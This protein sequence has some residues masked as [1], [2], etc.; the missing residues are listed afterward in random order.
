VADNPPGKEPFASTFVLLWRVCGAYPW[1]VPTMVL[2]GLMA[3]LAE[4]LGIGLLIPA[5]DE[6]LPGS[7]LGQAPG[8]L[9]SQLRQWSEWLPADSRLMVLGLA[10]LALVGLKTLTLIANTAL[11]S[12]VGTRIAHDMRNRLTEAVLGMQYLR[13][14]D[15]PAG[16]LINLLET[17]AY[18]TGE[19]VAELSRLLV[20]LCTVV[21]FSILLALLSFQLAIV[22]ALCILPVSVFV[23]LMTR[24]SR[25]LG[26]VMVEAYSRLSG[27]AI[28]LVTVMKSLR[29]LA[30]EK[31]GAHRIKDASDAVRRANLRSDIL[32]GSIQPV[33]EFMYVPIFMAVLI[34]S[35]SQD[36]AASGL[37]AFFALLYR[38][39]SPLKR[40]DQLRV[41][42]PSYT[43][44]IGDIQALIE[45]A[46]LFPAGDGGQASGGDSVGVEVRDIT[47]RYPGQVTP[48]LD[49]VSLSLPPGKVIA[50][51]GPSGSGKSTLAALLCRLLEP[52]SGEIL[53]N[54]RPL[55]DISSQ[56]WRQRVAYAGQDMELIDGS[57]RDNLLLGLPGNATYD[58]LVEV[59]ADARANEFLAD[60]DGLEMRTGLQGRFLSG[61]QR[62]RIILARAFLR[63]PDLL[64]LDEATNALD[65]A[66]ERAISEA[67]KAR[68]GRCT[69]LVITHRLETIHD[70]DWVYVLSQG[71]IVGEGTPAEMTGKRGLLAELGADVCQ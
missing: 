10:I 22:V 13:A 20:A 9:A 54:G 45:E 49:R 31:E 51:I 33:V 70:A 17:Q 62:Q 50:V 44:G 25:R 30:A 18:R 63:A 68:K 12:W 41:V 14:T 1:A 16:H 39:Q 35:A 67:I 38:L 40:L 15:H 3:S 57:V 46:R 48:S 61:G 29:L 23:W 8:P 69:M 58:R 7:Q 34:Y 36:I 66:T 60:R 32:T 65:S 26:Q 52:D 5:L 64:I 28:E 56:E 4:G 24:Q 37:V 71:G 59:L 27:R 43:S 6:L 42:L 2:L 53:V 11:T 55:A 19:A 21:T 47:F